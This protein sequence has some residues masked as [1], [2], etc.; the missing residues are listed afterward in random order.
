MASKRPVVIGIVSDLHCGSTLGLCP[1]EGVRLDDDGAYTPSKAQKWIWSNW[2]SYW[3]DVAKIRDE[4]KAKLICVYNGDAFEGDHHRT[5]QIISRNPEPQAYVASRVFSVP[6][7]LTPDQQYLV[8]GTEAHVGPSGASEEGFARSINAE[9][10]PETRTWSWWHLILRA[11][12]VLLDFKHHPSIRGQLPW[13]APQASQRLAFLVWTEHK[14]RDL[15]HPHLAIRSHTHVHRDSQDA[16]PTRAIITPAWQLKTGFGHQVAADS[17]ADVGG[18]IVVIQPDGTYEVT[19]K[20][21]LP[22]QTPVME[23]A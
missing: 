10:N 22:D 20:L 3:K 12:G 6:N 14:L 1:P 19:K 13:T 4:Q 15:P 5:S 2:C 21:F 7:D 18:I 8:R 9:R 16:F 23:V 11:H 17:I